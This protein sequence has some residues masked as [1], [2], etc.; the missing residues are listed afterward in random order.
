LADNGS[1][2]SKVRFVKIGKI[3]ALGN[4]KF[5]VLREI[6]SVVP[7]GDALGSV[8]PFTAINLDRSDRGFNCNA[9]QHKF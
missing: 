2:F 7:Y 5:E 6:L 3:L 1:K 4:P 9:D 8:L